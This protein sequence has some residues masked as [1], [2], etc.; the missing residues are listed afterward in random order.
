MNFG[1]KITLSKATGSDFAI[2][3]IKFSDLEN[4]KQPN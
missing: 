4:V 3:K 1:G 2:C